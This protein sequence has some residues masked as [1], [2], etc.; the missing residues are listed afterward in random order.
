MEI[1]N[2]RRVAHLNVDRASYWIVDLRDPRC[3]DDV[4][5]HIERHG[6]LQAIA[7]PRFAE[8]TENHWVR[9]SGAGSALGFT[10]LLGLVVGV[11][12]VG[13]TLYAVTRE[14]LKELATLKAIGATD[15]EKVL[16]D[17]HDAHAL[18]DRRD[19]LHPSIA[20]WALQRVDA[21]HPPQ[22]PRPVDAHPLRRHLPRPALAHSP[23]RRPKSFR[24]CLRAG[25]RRI[26]GVPVTG[27]DPCR[28]G[29]RVGSPIPPM[30]SSART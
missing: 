1:E 16:Q 29:C 23:R 24:Q 19:H 6:D 13:Q 18:G 5:A 26:M 10:A 21:P 12:I 11:V 20:R 30:R 22:Q 28:R 4:V 14:H 7:T 2:A 15:G 27:A 8:L 9:E 25:V 17:A 3:A